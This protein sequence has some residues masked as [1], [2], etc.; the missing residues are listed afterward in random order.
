MQKSKIKIDEAAWQKDL[1]FIKAMIRCEIDL[2][3]FGVEAARKDLAK[4]DPQLQFALTLFPG[5]AAAARHEQD[6]VD[7]ASARD[8][9]TSN[10]QPPTSK[11]LRSWELGL[12]RC[13]FARDHHPRLWVPSPKYCGV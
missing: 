11:V 6:H 10:F 8:S 4:S 9:P 2:D 7:A 3:L 12:G 13:W 1:P 5:G